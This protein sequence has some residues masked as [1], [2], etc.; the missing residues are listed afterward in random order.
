MCYLCATYVLLIL[1]MFYLCSTYVLLMYYLFYLCTT[2][3]V[4][5]SVFQC[6][7]SMLF[8]VIMC[9]LCATCGTYVLL[10]C[11]LCATYVLRMCCLCVTYVLFM[12]HR[13]VIYVPPMCYLCATYVLL[14]C[15]LCAIYVLRM[16]YLCATYVQPMCYPCVT[17]V[18]FMCHESAAHML[19]IMCRATYVLLM[20]YLCSTYSQSLRAFRRAESR[21]S[22]KVR[23]MIDWLILWPSPAGPRCTFAVDAAR[24]A[25]INRCQHETQ[26]LSAWNAFSGIAAV[27]SCRH[28][29]AILEDGDCWSG[30]GAASRV[31]VFRVAAIPWETHLA[32][33]PL[34]AN[35][36]QNSFVRWSALACST[37]ALPLAA[38][39]I[40]PLS[41]IPIE[42][43]KPSR[44]KAQVRPH[45]RTFCFSSIAVART[46]CCDPT[47]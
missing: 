18:L 28:S 47:P 44:L 3:S 31:L 36:Q 40:A 32:A 5:F 46:C 38:L 2:Y 6:V 39:N 4:S 30:P 7:F 25:V 13:C 12:C 15:Y 34:S 22:C 19:L 35:R 10:M 37:A 9:Y 16:C 11:R 33:L 24:D 42:R 17:Y 27:G 8:N 45:G 43:G 26:P 21:R 23:G 29:R 1:L 20:Y 41:A 14:L